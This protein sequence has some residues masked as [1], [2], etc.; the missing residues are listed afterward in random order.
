[1]RRGGVGQTLPCMPVCIARKPGGQAPP[2]QGAAV[3]QEVP[4]AQ[5]P[6]RLRAAAHA[7]PPQ[8]PRS[9][10][11][12][13]RCRGATRTHLSPRHV[14][15]EQEAVDG[16]SHRA[17]LFLRPS[18]PSAAQSG[19][20][21]QQHAGDVAS[22]QSG[23]RRSAWISSFQLTRGRLAE[24]ACGQVC[25]PSKKRC[26]LKPRPPPESVAKHGTARSAPGAKQSPVHSQS[27]R[28]LPICPRACRTR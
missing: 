12:R 28:C 6:Q 9:V 14:L 13:R 27:I 4:Q 11:A 22:R 17:H 18:R 26:S 1:M 19:L 16:G 8:M 2:P 25:I 20:S 21:L 3:S 23:K 10:R 24:G 15:G 5:D 7:R